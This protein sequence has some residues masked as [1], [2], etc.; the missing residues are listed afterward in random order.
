MKKK[1]ATLWGMD[2]EGEIVCPIIYL[3]KTRNGI[4]DADNLGGALEHGDKVLAEKSNDGW[5]KVF[6]NI[7]HEGKEYPQVGF[8]RDTLVRFD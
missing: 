5:V 1:H 2:E 3:W 8:I 6:K 7:K 4:L